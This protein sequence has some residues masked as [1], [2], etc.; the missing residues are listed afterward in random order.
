MLAQWASIATDIGII[1]GLLSPPL[2]G[3]WRTMIRPRV[4][5]PAMAFLA[6]VDGGVK[7][8]DRI[9][10]QV[11]QIMKNIGPNGGAALMDKVD[12]LAARVNLIIDDLP[13]PT[14]EASGTGRNTTVNHQFE[15]TFGYSA[16]ELVGNGWKALVHPK[17]ADEYFEAWSAAVADVRPFVI[18]ASRRMRFV[19]KDGHVMTVAVSASPHVTNNL[20][21]WMGTVRVTSLETLGPR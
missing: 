11:A 5:T 18:P 13:W 12:R 1:L 10:P 19:A 2:Y 3:V 9:E 21:V 8:L 14:F 4:Y 17:D 20:T 15:R 7:T 16:A 6:R